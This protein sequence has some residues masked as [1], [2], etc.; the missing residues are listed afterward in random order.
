MGY[1][2]EFDGTISFNKIVTYEMQTFINRF[3]HNR[4][5]KRDPKLIPQMDPE[6]QKHCYRGSLGPGAMYYYPPD[7]IAVDKI[8]RKSPWYKTDANNMVQNDFGQIMDISVLKDEPPDGVPG[9]WCQWIINNDGD[10][11]WD[12]G[13][14]F[15]NYVEWLKFLI[16]HFF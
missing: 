1:T 14:K 7:K 3:S 10:L 11:E 15:Y 8:V 2:T 4:H 9:Y 5:V 6:W 13:E 16:T 12:G